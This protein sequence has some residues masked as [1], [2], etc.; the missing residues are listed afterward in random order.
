MLNML[1]EFIIT[2]FI[3]HGLKFSHDIRNHYQLDPLQ[4]KQ[5]AR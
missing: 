3:D 4:N 2:M 5:Y 1:T